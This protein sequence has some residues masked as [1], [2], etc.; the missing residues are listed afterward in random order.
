MYY[1]VVSLSLKDGWAE[2]W[3]NWQ[4]GWRD[5]RTTEWREEGERD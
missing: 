5:E 1:L 4:T 2:K 3:L